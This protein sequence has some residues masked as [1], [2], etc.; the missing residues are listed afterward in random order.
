M[1]KVK[2]HLAVMRDG[3]HGGHIYGT[4]CGRESGRALNR[5]DAD[6][7]DCKLCLQI[8]AAPGHWRHRKW[9]DDS[10]KNGVLCTHE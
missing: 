10:N 9:L 3:A 2:T 4:L 5:D 7:V 8:M 6:K 1:A